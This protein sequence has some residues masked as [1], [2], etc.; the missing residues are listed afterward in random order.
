MPEGA[1]GL[2]FK[3]LYCSMKS[4]LFFSSCEVV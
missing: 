4:A 2:G 1:K 3:F